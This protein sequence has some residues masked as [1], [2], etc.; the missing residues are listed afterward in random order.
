MTKD[1]TMD[2]TPN[3]NPNPAPNPSI[4]GAFLPPS[5]TPAPEG[6]KPPAGAPATFDPVT[7]LIRTQRENV[8]Y[9][10]TVLAVIF[11]VAGV[12]LAVKS[13]KLS[14]STS[15][16][17][18]KAKDEKDAENPLKDLQLDASEAVQPNRFDYVIG[19]I[20][21][22]L[23]LAATAF[24][25]AYLIVGFPKKTEDEQRREARVLVLSVG[26]NL[27]ASLIF[28]GAWLFYRW[29]DSLV[30][31]LDKGD[32]REARWV[33]IPLLMVVLGGGIMFLSIQPARAEERNNTSIRR[34]VYGAN[35]GL[36][37]LLLFVVLVI[38]NAVVALR[39]PNKLDTT[40]SGFYTLSPQTKQVLQSLDQPIHAYAIFQDTGDLVTA[41]TKRLL[42]SARDESAGKFQVRFL[43]PALNRDEIS[44]L[45]AE[46][47]MAEMSREGV[48]LVAG[49]GTAE[50]KRH[51]FIRDDEFGEQKDGPDGRPIASFNGEPKLLRELMFLAEN[52]NK[53]KVYFT[54]SSGELSFAPGGRGGARRS[55]TMLKGY[56]ERNY[57]DVAPL[58]FDIG[59]PAKVP[60]DAAV[61]V[62][63]DPVEPLPPNGV[64]AI[65]DY[66]SKPR[67][68]GKKGKLIVLAGTQRG[69]DDK[70]LVLGLEPVIAPFGVRLADRFMYNVPN[71]RV[72]PRITLAVVNPEGT[73]A[74]NPVALGF[75]KVERL[76]LLDC[77]EVSSTPAGGFQPVTVLSSLP[78]RTTWTE[79][80][81]AANPIEAWQAVLERVKAIAN[82]PGNEEQ[83]EK[84][85]RELESELQIS[86][87]SRGLA[88]FVSER[89]R[90][91]ETARVAVFGNGWFVSDDAGAQGS[92]NQAATLW[93]DLMGSTLDWIRDRPTVGGETTKQYTSYTLKPGF[94]QMRLVYV[95]L[96]VGFLIVMG[97]GA[98]VWVIRRK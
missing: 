56:L 38:V 32:L 84:Q 89:E 57:F 88:I 79:A 77:R 11:L 87:R 63:A 46:F 36:M 12:M 92:R 95:P 3:P 94:D 18:D 40:G 9:F 20:G 4:P 75:T 23:G 81:Y 51:S 29:S 44:K 2:P 33:L 30:K 86:R 70:P 97:L 96:G 13:N 1:P 85:F 66:M 25:A 14:G 62:V 78:G 26:G 31:W 37:I 65:R 73:E 69:A 6:A 82:G 7:E 8:G 64:E 21:C 22:G 91:K 59:K 28:I 83:K 19:A 60:D 72:D 52:K 17:T 43:S 71:E 10:L 98:G 90:E 45:K 54:Q 76:P 55:A 47:P 34:A 35:F 39:L 15:T 93:F 49:E 58:T 16:A 48:L 42:E 50:R 24:G 53:P 61:V 27:G 67:P 74:R 41:D 80:R 5:G 68:D